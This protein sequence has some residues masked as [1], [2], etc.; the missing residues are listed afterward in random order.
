MTATTAIIVPTH[1]VTVIVAIEPVTLIGVA[2]DAG[3]E[4]VGQPALRGGF[5][6]RPG[7]AQPAGPIR[8]GRL[9]LPGFEARYEPADREGRQGIDAEDA[10]P[11][12]LAR[13]SAGKRDAI[14]RRADLGKIGCSRFGQLDPA[15]EAAE[16]RRPEPR[17]ER[18]DLPA[19]RA[20]GH[21]KLLAGPRESEAPRGGLE[22][23]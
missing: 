21:V 6:G 8:P 5:S 11:P 16:E 7:E 15:V 1:K 12:L 2:V 23:P 22:G 4:K 13:A 20:V 14:E 3:A 17:L 10:D 19:D 18:L 9:E